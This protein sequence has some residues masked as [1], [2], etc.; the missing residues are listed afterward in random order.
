MWDLRQDQE[1]L[2]NPPDNPVSGTKAASMSLRAAS[3]FSWHKSLG[4]WGFRHMFWVLIVPG[5][6][7]GGD[8]A[9]RVTGDLS[10]QNVSSFL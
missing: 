6:L 7:S 9:A 3:T 4:V 2:E 10:P 5:P 1:G 8:G